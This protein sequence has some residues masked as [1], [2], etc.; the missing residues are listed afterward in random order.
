MQTFDILPDQIQDALESELRRC[1]D[2]IRE[3][4]CS[5]RRQDTLDDKQAA[6]A[7]LAE[8][9]RKLRTLRQAIFD[10]EDA[11][12]FALNE[13]NLDLFSEYQGLF[14]KAH[15]AIELCLN[16]TKDN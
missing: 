5:V 3:L 7:K 4:R 2:R 9:E 8:T 15:S 13:Q 12:L 10:A 14:K 11:A 16:P 1:K 6:E